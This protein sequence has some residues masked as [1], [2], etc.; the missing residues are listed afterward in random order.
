[1][2][3]PE[4]VRQDRALSGL[5]PRAGATRRVSLNFHLCQRAVGQASKQNKTK[6]NETKQNKTEQK[7]PTTKQNKKNPT[8]PRSVKTFIGKKK[9]ISSHGP[10]RFSLKGEKTTS[11][12][13]QIATASPGTQ[14]RAPAFCCRRDKLVHLWGERN[15]NS[16]LPP[17]WANT[18]GR[19]GIATP[20]RRP[21]PP[22]PDS[23]SIFPFF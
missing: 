13:L 14:V 8:H 19:G 10:F 20:T 23:S 21:P 9:N 16:P 18:R 17:P 6:Q 3:F 12:H 15:T 22:S 5:L 11:R 4:K 1:M 7:K 2:D